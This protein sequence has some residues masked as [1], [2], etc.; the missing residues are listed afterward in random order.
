MLANTF[1][2]YYIGTET[3]PLRFI[4]FV[5]A[6]SVGYAIFDVP[7]REG[8]ETLPYE[9][10]TN[11]CLPAVGYA[12]FDVPFRRFVVN[13]KSYDLYTTFLPHP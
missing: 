9:Y 1:V 5:S 8:T 7:S 4:I 6:K 2:I 13:A 11:V 10:N 3:R 12:I